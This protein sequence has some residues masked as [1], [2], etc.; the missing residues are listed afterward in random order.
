MELALKDIQMVH[1]IKAIILTEKKMVL[2]VIIGMMELFMKENGKIILS[3]DMGF[4]NLLMG[5]F[6]LENGIII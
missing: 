3:M 4:I 2:V 5:E 6:I 1:F